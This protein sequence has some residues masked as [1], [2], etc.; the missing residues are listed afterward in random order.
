MNM[1]YKQSSSNMP[2]LFLNKEYIGLYH[3]QGFI[4]SAEMC[5]FIQMK[6]HTFLH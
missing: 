1:E 6:M 4:C 2:S 5:E 3:N